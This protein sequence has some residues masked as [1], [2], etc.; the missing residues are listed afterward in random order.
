MAG[1]SNTES[2]AWPA[3]V[4]HGN[5]MPVTRNVPF[6]FQD[7]G[8]PGT[9]GAPGAPGAAATIAVGSVATGAPGSPVSVSNSGTS[10]AAVFDFSI[11]EGEPGTDADCGTSCS[12]AENNVKSYCDMT[13]LLIGDKGASLK[14]PDGRNIKIFATES[15]QFLI[16][17]RLTIPLTAGPTEID[18]RF[19]AIIEPGTL[20]VM[21]CHVPGPV[22][23]FAS[24]A[25]PRTKNQE[26]ANPVLSVFAERWGSATTD[27]LPANLEATVTLSAIRKGAA[28]IYCPAVA[29]DQEVEMNN[30]FLSRCHGQAPPAPRHL[31]PVPCC[32]GGTCEAIAAVSGMPLTPPASPE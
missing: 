18:P 6:A 8:P 1:N 3:A 14:L 12:T 15:P 32:P 27:K 22:H 5:S 26:P 2:A 31:P 29:T 20:A 30:L 24:I 25:Q 10:S 7:Q 16:I 19:L 9:P 21:A 17:E 4:K 13:F 11:P 23:S 28:D